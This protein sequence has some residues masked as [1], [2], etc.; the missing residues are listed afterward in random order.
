MLT[1]KADI[2]SLQL[3]LNQP[4]DASMVAYL[5]MAA[6]EVMVLL[7]LDW[8]VGVSERDL[9]TALMPLLAHPAADA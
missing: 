6:S 8:N 5:A 3:F 9:F 1:Q 7:L 2:A 4:M